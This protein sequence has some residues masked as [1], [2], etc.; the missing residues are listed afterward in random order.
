[1]IIGAS[2]PMY[3]VKVVIL[4][5]HVIFEKKTKMFGTI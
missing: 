5:F 1:M 2:N 4:L 3:L